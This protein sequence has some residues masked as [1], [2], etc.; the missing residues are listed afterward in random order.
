MNPPIGWFVLI[1]TVKDFALDAALVF[2][3]EEV[4]FPR[5]ARRFKHDQFTILGARVNRSTHNIERGKPAVD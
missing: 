2:N 1:H 4:L 3:I 5:T